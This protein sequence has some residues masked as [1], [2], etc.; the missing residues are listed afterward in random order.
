MCPILKQAHIQVNEKAYK[1][2][3]QLFKVANHKH[4]TFV[5][6]PISKPGENVSKAVELLLDRVML[7][8]DKVMSLPG[9]MLSITMPPTGNGHEE[10]N[11]RISLENSSEN[12]KCNC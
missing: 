6:S 7:R 3:F 1:T 9:R 8:M 10:N 4:K 5:L 12:S 11:V 2:G